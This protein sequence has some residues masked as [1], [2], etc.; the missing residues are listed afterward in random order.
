[1]QAIMV[2]PNSNADSCQYLNS[3]STNHITNSSENF[4]IGHEYLGGN[5]IHVGNRVGLDIHHIGSSLLQP[6]KSSTASNIDNLPTFRIENLLHVPY[7]T[8]SLIS[9]SP[10]AMDNHGYFEFHPFTCFVND[11]ITTIVFLWRTFTW[12]TLQVQY[13]KITSKFFQFKFQSNRLF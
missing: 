9:V 3:S 7:M 1:M 8:K 6:L 11:Q 5:Q 10:F 2:T 12:R 4:I 13:D